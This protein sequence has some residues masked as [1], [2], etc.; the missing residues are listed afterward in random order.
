MN[1]LPKVA[2]KR[3]QIFKLHK[4]VLVHR[5]MFLGVT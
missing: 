2:H 4:F 3:I 1:L 5:K